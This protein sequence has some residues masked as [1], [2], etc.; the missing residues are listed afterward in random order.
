MHETVPSYD[1]DC[2]I[3]QIFSYYTLHAVKNLR[4]IKRSYFH[5]LREIMKIKKCLHPQKILTVE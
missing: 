5:Q 2:H 4:M 3:K 1:F